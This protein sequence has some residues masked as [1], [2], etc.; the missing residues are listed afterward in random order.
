MVEEFAK[1]KDV[2]N[3]RRSEYGGAGVKLLAVLLVIVLV[4]NAGYNYVP[5]AYEGE[6]FKQEMQ[7]AVINGMSMPGTKPVDNVKARIQRAAA[8]NRLPPDMFLDVRQVGNVVQ[9]QVV[10]SK[11]VD[12]LPFGL[13]N[14]IYHFDHTATPTGFL[15]KAN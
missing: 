15:M 12:L 13:Y 11:G 1:M 6:N 14:Y 3:D 5:V 10:Y 8:A 2:I 9:A 7:T 4:A